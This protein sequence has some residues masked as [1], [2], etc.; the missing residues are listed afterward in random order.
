VSGAALAD[1]ASDAREDIADAIDFTAD[2]SR[3]CERR[4][5]P[6]LKDVMR[7]LRPRRIT[8]LR[9]QRAL[10]DLGDAQEAADACGRRVRRLLRSAARSL[11]AISGD[12]VDDRRDRRDHGRAEPRPRPKKL[13]PVPDRSWRSDCKT[14]W[15]MIE[16][17]DMAGASRAD[18]AAV[19]QIGN[20]ACGNQ[21]LG[22]LTWPSGKT[23]RYRNG[24]WHYPNGKTARYANGE[25]HYPNGKTARYANGELHYP[26]GK[27][28]KYANGE[29]HYPNGR[30]AGN[31][32]SVENF[33]CGASRDKCKLYRERR[34]TTDPVFSELLLVREAWQAN[35]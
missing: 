12:R 19:A 26:N 5:A 33:A 31:W 3:R 18:R 8:R 17:I 28:A 29:W 20:L 1:D 13:A 23:A 6:I 25:L 16:M 9:A 10:A 7:A 30:R 21:P 24:E 14:Q 22:E 35:R 34:R 15:Y 32:Q 4:V 27:T 11:R 2:D